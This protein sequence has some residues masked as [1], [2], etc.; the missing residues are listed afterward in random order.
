MMGINARPLSV[1]T[2]STRGGTSAYVRR[3]TIP[4]SSR[5][6]SLSDKVRGEM[7][8]SDRSSSQNRER[9]S[10]RSRTTRIVHL[11]QTM[12]AVRHTGQSLFTIGCQSSH[13]ASRSEA[14]HDLALLHAAQHAE[15]QFAARG[16]ERVEE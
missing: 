3:R 16:V 15:R 5:A 12:S 13:N 8:V 4:S 9:P 2:Y 10:A 7:P 11:A 14:G 1:R 6:R